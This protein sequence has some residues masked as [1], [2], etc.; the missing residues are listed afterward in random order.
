MYEPLILHHGHPPFSNGI[1]LKAF[2]SIFKPTLN[3]PN[4]LLH[5]IIE[6]MNTFAYYQNY[7][8]IFFTSPEYFGPAVR[9][10]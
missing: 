5:S 3:S 2:Y 10:S 4:T 1:L 7:S 6:F 8:V 9:S